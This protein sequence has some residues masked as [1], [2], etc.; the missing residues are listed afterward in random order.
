LGP[1]PYQGGAL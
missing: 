1:P